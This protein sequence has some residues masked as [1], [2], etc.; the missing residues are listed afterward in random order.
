[1]EAHRDGATNP[2][3]R[4]DPPGDSIMAQE[5]LPPQMPEAPPQETPPMLSEAPEGIMGGDIQS[6]ALQMDEGKADASATRMVA[7][8]KA[9]MYG[10]QF[11]RFMDVLQNSENLPEDTAI[12]TVNLIA[13]EVEAAATTN[14]GVTIDNML[15]FVANVNNEVWNLAFETGTYQPSS[16]DEIQRVQNISLTMAMGELGKMLSGSDLL[17]D[18][19]VAKFMENVMAGQYD[20]PQSQQAFVEADERPPEMPPSQTPMVMA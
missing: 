7:S 13:P 14:L 3:W 4:I 16:D 12:L 20:S 5:Q 17:G 8:A 2:F 6:Q 11:D 15:Y 1:M 18:D 9:A 10:D 19:D